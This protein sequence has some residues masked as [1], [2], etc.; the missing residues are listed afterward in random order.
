MTGRDPAFQ[1]ENVIVSNGFG[2]FH[3]RLAAAEAGQRNALAAFITGA[4]PT[5]GLSRLVTGLGVNRFPAVARFLARSEPIPADRTHA[6]W[7]GEPFSQLGSRAR[8]VSFLSSGFAD[9]LHLIARGLYAGGA[10]RILKRLPPADG[11][12]V[13][14]YRAGFGGKS[15]DLARARGWVC[16]CDHTIAHPA[17]LEFLVQNEGRMPPVGESGPVDSNWQAILDDINR[18][19]HVLT[20]SD[21]VKSTFA[22]QGWD[23]GKVDVIYLGV[24]DGFLSSIP[25]SAPGTD[26]PLRLLFAGSFNRRKG[27]PELGEAVQQLGEID[28][29]LDICGPVGPESADAF[30]SLSADSRVT[31]HGNLP[32][33]DLA[34]RMAAADVFVF[35]TLAEGSARVLFEAMAAGC[36]MITTANGGSVVADGEH[37]E[38]IAP[39]SV[40][41]IAA[42]IRRA[43][44]DRARV[45]EIGARNA[46]LVRERYRQGDYG[47]H[48]F[49]LYDR[50]LQR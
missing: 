26:G 13:Y 17:V 10:S 3:M 43:A 28:W 46:A 32:S 44:A 4:Y 6:L 29:T 48:L 24:D 50:L 38:L 25:E 23:G 37:G 36:Y 1:A 40:A 31:Y 41:D 22:Q 21:F 34:A 47:T 20:N 42:A 35:P 19:D 2:R 11:Q 45:R 18:S 9:R 14:H 49:A 33:A 7:A 12:G 5:A 15:V 8:T 30:A 27:G 39:G 16:L